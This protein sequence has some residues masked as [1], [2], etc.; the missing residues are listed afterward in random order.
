MTCGFKSSVIKDTLNLWC[1]CFYIWIPKAERR[2]NST[3]QC[4]C[5][6]RNITS[7]L[8]RPNLNWLAFHNL[9]RVTIIQLNLRNLLM[10]WKD[11]GEVFTWRAPCKREQGRM[12]LILVLYIEN[13]MKIDNWHIRALS[14]PRTIEKSIQGSNLFK[15]T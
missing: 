5:R 3:T 7:S 14:G 4:N 1:N 8:L 15:Q 13:R 6:L 12:L 11:G 9:I 2:C 10:A